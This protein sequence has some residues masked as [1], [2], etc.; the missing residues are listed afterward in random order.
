MMFTTE[1]MARYEGNANRAKLE[2]DGAFVL[3]QVMD[4]C[5]AFNADADFIRAN[6]GK[7]AYTEILPVTNYVT[8][9]IR[10]F[11]ETVTMLLEIANTKIVVS[12][13]LVDEV[14][15]G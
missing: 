7:F 1:Q 4:L 2:N 12:D 13:I 3:F 9:D 5:F 11:D 10:D 15:L 14:I 6:S 8:I